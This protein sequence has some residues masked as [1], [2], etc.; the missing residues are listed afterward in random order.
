M[1]SYSETGRQLENGRMEHLRCGVL[2]VAFEES[3]VRRGSM[4]ATR[5]F[6][7]ACG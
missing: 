2:G 4:H 1:S 5:A 6:W 7:T 3:S